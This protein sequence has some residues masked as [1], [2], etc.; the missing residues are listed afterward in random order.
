[1]EGMVI[2]GVAQGTGKA[3]VSVLDVPDRPGV[4]FKIFSLLGQN[5]INVDV[6]LQSVMRDS[7]RDIA[8]TIDEEDINETLQLLEEN[9]PL[10]DYS[11]LAVDRDIV[12]V[13]IVGAGMLSNSGIASRMF[14]ALYE[15]GINI[16]MITTSEIK[17]SVILESK[18][19]DNA[20][21]VIHDEFINK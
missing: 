20:V 15:A 14:G 8:F 2:K 21:N 4:A 5:G 12:K 16:K 1:M 7:K 19:A 10:F 11:S 9:Q 13:S 18:D 6:I 17:I 3:A